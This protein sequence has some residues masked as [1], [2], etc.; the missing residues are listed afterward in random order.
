MSL[1]CSSLSSNTSFRLFPTSSI[2]SSTTTAEIAAFPVAPPDVCCVFEATTFPISW[3][4]FFLYPFCNFPFPFCLL[5]LLVHI[6]II[7]II[8]FINSSCSSQQPSI[9]FLSNQLLPLRPS[10]EVELL[11]NHITTRG[12]CSGQGAP[13]LDC[14]HQFIDS[15]SFLA[16]AIL[17]SYSINI[18]SDLYLLTSTNEQ[19]FLDLQEVWQYPWF[20]LPFLESS[21]KKHI[22]LIW[23]QLSPPSLF[24]FL[25][26]LTLE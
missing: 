7:V 3:M 19:R 15:F 6:F 12:V 22:K 14:L 17:Y 21:L 16:L 9:L 4:I 11:S 13:S 2:F 10:V 8:I 25:V 18:S 1:I 23:R 5:L 26:F 20:S 24:P